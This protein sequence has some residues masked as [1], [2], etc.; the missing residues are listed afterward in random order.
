M[1]DD[2]DADRARLLPATGLR[3]EDRTR[4]HGPT[5]FLRDASSNIAFCCS[6]EPWTEKSF[7]NLN[8]N[9]ISLPETVFML[10][11]AEKMPETSES[12]P[13]IGEHILHIL[14]LITTHEEIS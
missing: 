10:A 1:H 3:R 13:L 8:L 14:L 4:R 11:I 12:I 7:G 5:C 9:S 2:V 6:I